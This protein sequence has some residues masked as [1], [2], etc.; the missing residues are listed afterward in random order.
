MN[1]IRLVVCLAGTLLQVCGAHQPEFDRYEIRDMPARE[2][3]LLADFNAD[4]TTNDGLKSNMLHPSA[5]GYQLWADA[6]KPTL[7]KLL[8]DSGVSA[9]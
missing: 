6:V 9:K 2:R 7:D 1:S 5:K 8:K 4:G 3:L